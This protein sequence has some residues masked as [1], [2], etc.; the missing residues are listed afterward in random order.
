MRHIASC[1][2][3]G[4]QSLR[5]SRRGVAAMEFAMVAPVM[6]IMIWGVYDVAGAL[7]AWEE[8]VHAA[9]AVAQAA[10]KLSINIDPVTG[11]TIQALTS[12]QMQTAMTSIYAEMPWLQLGNNTGVFNGPYSVTLSGVA[13]TPTCNARQYL[14]N[15][16]L[17]NTQVPTILWSSY[18]TEGGAQLDTPP[19]PP[20]TNT[21]YRLCT[22]API[23]VA[24]FPNTASQLQY[25]IDPNLVPGG[26]MSNMNLIPQ[27][28][29]DVKYT[30]K[31]TFP[32]FSQTSITFYASAT[33]PAPLG[34]EDQEIV[35]DERDS[36]TNT[37]EACPGGN[38]ITK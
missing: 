20:A 38:A 1:M 6:A 28:V 15:P 18:L 35:F 34:D 19:P 32:L 29:A 13:F 5:A 7:L 3:N 10:E 26:Q 17:C 14:A 22:P 36:P 4:A 11:K 9:Q 12:T 8:T 30:F 24:Q 27:V 16:T 21:L 37:V 33:F 31:P 23:P 2:P 25:M